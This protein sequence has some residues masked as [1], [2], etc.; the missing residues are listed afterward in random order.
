VVIGL[1]S[2]TYIK[3]DGIEWPGRSSVW[4]KVAR[5]GTA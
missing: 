4:F 1:P 5:S 2:L 3:S